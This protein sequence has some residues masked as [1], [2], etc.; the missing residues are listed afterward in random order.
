ME[1]K[2]SNNKLKKARRDGILLKSSAISTYFPVLLFFVIMSYKLK[3]SWLD[4]KL[5]LKLCF[6]GDC[7][8]LTGYIL[9]RGFI[10]GVIAPLSVFCS[11]A[12][13]TEILQVLMM[14]V[15]GLIF[16]NTRLLNL[17]KFIESTKDYFINLINYREHLLKLVLAPSMALF[18]ICVLLKDSFFILR[19]NRSSVG[20]INEIMEK[21]CLSAFSLLFCLTLVILIVDFL[22]A[23]Y[24]FYKKLS[25]TKDEIKNEQKEEEGNP[26]VRSFGRALHMEMLSSDVVKKIRNSKVVIVEYS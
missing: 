26:Y 21:F 24:G 12:I 4:V 16:G 3:F 7:Y 25:M 6:E 8:Y 9:Y 11:I 22:N 20:Q 19:D 1:E 23:R 15:G 18:A 13:L 2:P 14:N 10:I 5:L 17:S